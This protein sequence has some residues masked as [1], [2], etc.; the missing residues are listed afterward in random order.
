MNDISYIEGISLIDDLTIHHWE[1]LCILYN[2]NK[3]IF[4]DSITFISDLLEWRIEEKTTFTA[5]NMTRR[6]IDDKR[7][8]I[9][10][11]TGLLGLTCLNLD[12]DSVILTEGVSDFFST[13]LLFPDKNVLG[14][15]TLSTSFFGKMFLINVFKNFIIM[16]DNDFSKKV[17][18]GINNS[19][20]LSKLLNN[21][22]R[23]KVITPPLPNKDITDYLISNI[24]VNRTIL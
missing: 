15:T 19:L 23:T 18:T 8:T 24:K 20:S 13:K 2:A 22:G 12:D 14:L 3:K 9:Q 16:S 11:D 17:N 10:D 21:Y 4:N 5:F 1:M 7:N 6:K